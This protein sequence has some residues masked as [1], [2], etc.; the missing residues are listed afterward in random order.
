MIRILERG[1]E[2]DDSLDDSDVSDDDEELLE[3]YPASQ[4]L[5]T[6]I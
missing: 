5:T 2:E 6:A 3:D 4:N 1:L